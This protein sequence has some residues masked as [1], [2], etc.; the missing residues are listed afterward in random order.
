MFLLGMY[1]EDAYGYLGIKYVTMIVGDSAGHYGRIRCWHKDRG[2]TSI[3]MK[4]QQIVG[5]FWM[6][7]PLR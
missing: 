7:E 2:F 6:W 4:Y 3:P 1:V 5:E